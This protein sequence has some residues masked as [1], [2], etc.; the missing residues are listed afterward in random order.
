MFHE[1]LIMLNQNHTYNTRAAT[2][3]INFLQ[4]QQVKTTR[5]GQ[6]SVMFQTPEIWN[7]FQRT[8][9]LDLLIFEPS[10]FKKAFFPAY[11][12]KYSKNN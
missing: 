4:I 8:Q 9:N 12:A 11:L 7:N 1:M 5:F 3:H 2:Y 10:E 6:Y